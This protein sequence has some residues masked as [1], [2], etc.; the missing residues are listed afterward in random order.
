MSVHLLSFGVI[1]ACAPGMLLWCLSLAASPAM[2]QTHSLFACADESGTVAYV[3]EPEDE[4]HCE[5]LHALPMPKLLMAYQQ[6][7][8]QFFSEPGSAIRQGDQLSVAIVTSYIDDQQ[9]LEAGYRSLRHV[10]QFDCQRG[11]G[12]AILQE[13]AF[14]ESMARGL[15]AYTLTT[16]D[17]PM[18]TVLAGSTGVALRMVLCAGDAS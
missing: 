18:Q 3:P 7:G 15:P 11:G 10:V 14:H 17:A 12:I 4:R 13:Q 9:A 5:L 6:P 16:P 8:I 2:A 1:R